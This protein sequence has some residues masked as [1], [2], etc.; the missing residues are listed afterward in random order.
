MATRSISVSGSGSM[1]DH[2]LL[3]GIHWHDDQPAGINVACS[4]GTELHI[5]CDLEGILSLDEL[6]EI[7]DGHRGHYPDLP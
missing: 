7:Q 5:E 6:R 4:C 2:D 1:S 3:V